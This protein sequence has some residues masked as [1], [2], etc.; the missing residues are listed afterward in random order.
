MRDKFPTLVQNDSA[1]GMQEKK[2]HV[3]RH[4]GPS[5]VG[6]GARAEGEHGWKAKSMA[7][8]REKM[9]GLLSFSCQL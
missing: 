2:N 6:M 5:A 3:H 8:E 7:G 9:L 4:P 1:R